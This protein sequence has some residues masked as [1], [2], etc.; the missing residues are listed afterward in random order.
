M[1]EADSTV[2]KTVAPLMASFQISD[3]VA[4]RLQCLVAKIWAVCGPNGA[5]SRRPPCHEGS[6]V[7]DTG[8]PSGCWRGRRRVVRTSRRRAIVVAAGC[9]ADVVVEVEDIVGVVA[10]LQLG[11]PGQL[12][13]AVGAPDAGLPSSVRSL[14]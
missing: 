13:R 8:A 1:I 4:S 14:T 6:G 10:V 5:R 11:Q 3:R 9:G 12:V 7:L 2:S